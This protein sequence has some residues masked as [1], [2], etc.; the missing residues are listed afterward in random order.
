[1]YVP[2]RHRW[3]AGFTLIELLI[4]VVVVGILAAV[5]YPSFMDSVRKGRRS[6]AFNLL[7][8]IQQAQERH[9]ANNADY[10]GSITGLTT[11]NPPG[12]GLST[13]TSG[14]GYYTASLSGVTPTGYSII[15]T[16][17][18]GK[19][20]ASD[21]NCQQLRLRVSGGAIFYGSAPGDSSFTESTSN[22]CWSR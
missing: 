7:N 19:S 1:M 3:H 4:A 18:A 12:L 5:A 14:N 22:L 13:A 20:Q 17:V 6:D 15:A 10:S 16:A 2:P 9:R 11:D 21:G 8:A